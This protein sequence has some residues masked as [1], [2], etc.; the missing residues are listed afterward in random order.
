MFC[1]S[2]RNGA[3]IEA[4]DLALEAFFLIFFVMRANETGAVSR[5]TADFGFLARNLFPVSPRAAPQFSGN[6]GKK[7][8]F[9]HIYVC[10]CVDVWVSR[11]ACGR[12][13]H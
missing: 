11:L 5:N 7:G 6:L 4:V 3:K 13:H 9:L 10:V 1:C 12:V 8:G 2:V